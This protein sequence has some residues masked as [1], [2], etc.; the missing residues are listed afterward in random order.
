VLEWL[1]SYGEGYQT[2]VN[3]LLRHA[4]MQTSRA[5][6]QPVTAKTARRA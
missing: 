4:M 2:K 1:K 5:A 6:E 3:M